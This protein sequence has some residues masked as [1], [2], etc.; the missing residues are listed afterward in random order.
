VPRAIHSLNKNSHCEKGGS[1]RRTN[2]AD[3]LS[4][5]KN[6]LRGRCPGAVRLVW[7]VCTVSQDLKTYT[8]SQRTASLFRPPCQITERLMRQ[9]GVAPLMNQ[10]GE[11]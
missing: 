11:W 8:L 9:R 5:L 2:G 1:Y 10:S 3:G 6:Q 4:A 7:E